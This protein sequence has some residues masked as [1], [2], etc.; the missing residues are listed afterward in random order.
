MELVIISFNDIHGN[1]DYLPQFSAFVKETRAKYEH[2]IVA[3]AGDWFNGNPY[4]DLYDPTQFPITDLLNHIGVDVSVLGNHE[5]DYGVKVLNDRIKELNGAVISANTRLKGSGLRGVKP[6]HIIRKNGIRIAFLGL[7][8]VD[9]LTGIPAVLSSRVE[10]MH[11]YEPVGKATKYRHLAEKSHVFVALT[12]I[13]LN[14]DRTLAD[15][16]PYIDLII[17]GHSHSILEQPVWINDVMII[18]AERFAARVGKTKILLVDGHVMEIT[19]ELIDFRNWD[20]PVDS[21]IVEKIKKYEGDLRFEQPFVSL[22]YEIQNSEQMTKMIT[23]AALAMTEADFSIV[24]LAAAKVRHFPAG[25]ITYGDILRLSPSNNELMLVKLKPADIREFLEQK[26]EFMTPSGFTYTAR[27]T[28]QG[29]RDIKMVLPNGE[30]VDE[31]KF[32]YLAVDSFLFSRYLRKHSE[33]STETGISV[34]DNIME[35]MKNNP[36]M[37]YRNSPRRTMPTN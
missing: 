15:T 1:F 34:V 24:N 20:G 27:R 37:D 17:S 3:N 22:Q 12:H 8:N 23:D 6:Y 26:I 33:Q 9:R 21:A 5:F 25:P 31:N 7:T 14:H 4:N 30:V 32:Y 11:F 19:N 35:F 16:M 10:G 28:P 18:Q 29:P 2:V 13:G 36:D